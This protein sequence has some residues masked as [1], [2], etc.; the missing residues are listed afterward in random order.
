MQVNYTPWSIVFVCIKLPITRK[1]IPS[2]SSMALRDAS[3]NSH[4]FTCDTN[5]RAH[6]SDTDALFFFFTSKRIL[7]KR[8]LETISIF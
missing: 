6:E 5:D 8:L 1:G 7:T 4:H 3:V 2:G